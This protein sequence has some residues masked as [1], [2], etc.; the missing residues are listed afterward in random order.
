MRNNQMN[1]EEVL[2]GLK[3]E[4]EKYVTEWV[5]QKNIL[6]LGEQLKMKV[7]LEIISAPD[8]VC[9][10]QMK[11]SKIPRTLKMIGRKLAHLIWY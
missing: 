9:E 5:N 4:I 7:N 11:T 3:V 1:Q 6:A 8:V 10:M 2:E